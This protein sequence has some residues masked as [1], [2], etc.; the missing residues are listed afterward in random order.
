MM[1]R[2]QRRHATPSQRRAA[3]WERT[4]KEARDVAMQASY[5]G[6]ASIL[7][8]LNEKYHFG[9]QRLKIVVGEA[10]R[11][12]KNAF[13]AQELID[14]LKAKAGIDLNFIAKRDMSGLDDEY[15]G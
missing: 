14:E 4:K 8:A 12:C 15:D 10:N 6:M 1:N 5:M 2:K 13:C 11:I 3:D 7:L 9:A